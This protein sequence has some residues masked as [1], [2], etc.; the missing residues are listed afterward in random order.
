MFQN[1]KISKFQNFKI[2]QSQN[3]KMSKFQ[4]LNIFKT[5][6]FQNVQPCSGSLPL[7]LRSN[8]LR[9]D[10]KSWKPKMTSVC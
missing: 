4:N 6:K 2:S 7:T 9:G 8:L 1:F 10:E 3:F 5:L